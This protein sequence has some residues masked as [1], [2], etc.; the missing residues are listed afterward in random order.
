MGNPRKTS[1]VGSETAGGDRLAALEPTQRPQASRAQDLDATRVPLTAH[2][3]H[4]DAPRGL[5]SARLVAVVVAVVALT[6]LAPTVDAGQV[7]DVGSLV[8]GTIS[9]DGHGFLRSH[10]LPMVPGPPPRAQQRRVRARLG[11]TPTT[12]GLEG[13]SGVDVG[14][15]GGGGAS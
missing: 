6:S 11:Q 10:H 14:A 15:G 12:R 9:V 13:V 5:A 4:G 2:A 8:D 7:V 1:P 3:V